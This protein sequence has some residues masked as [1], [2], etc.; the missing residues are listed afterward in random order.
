MFRFFVLA[1]GRSGSTMLVNYLSSHPLVRCHHEPFRKTGWHP[2]LLAYDKPLDAL[3]HISRSGLNISNYRRVVSYAQSALNKSTGNTIVAP[4]KR[5]PEDGIEGFKLTWAQAD[6]M[7]SQFKKWLVN[8]EGVKVI[9]LGRDD[10]LARYVSYEL[11]QRS[12]L[13]HAS[14]PPKSHV[15]LQVDPQKFSLFVSSQEK[16]RNSMRELLLK[17]DCE[18]TNISY[19]TLIAN[20]ETVM[21]GIFGFLGTTATRRLLRTTT[22]LVRPSLK[23]IITNYAELEQQ[24]L[25]SK[26][27]SE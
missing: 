21:K 24:G 27:E 19:E 26:T 23:D 8:Q 9:L 25:V 5:F 3:N 14:T 20:P 4:W 15:K 2:D 13:W 7:K 10:V 11:A 1:S 16:Q 18:F 6:S 22:K 12:G 17:T